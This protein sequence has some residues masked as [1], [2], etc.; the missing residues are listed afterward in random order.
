MAG[1]REV[2]AEIE[3][4]TRRQLFAHGFCSSFLHPP[5]RGEILKR[6]KTGGLQ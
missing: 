2:A 3:F 4:A 6:K 5:R 1:G